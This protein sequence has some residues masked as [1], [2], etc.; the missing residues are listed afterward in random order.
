MQEHSVHVKVSGRYLVEVPEGVGPFPLLAGFHGYGQTAEDELALL[1]R[2]PGSDRRVRCSI[3]ALHPFMNAKGEPGAS[4][5]TRLNRERRIA[6]N[7]AYVDTVIALVMTELP[8]DGRLVLHGF[9]QGAAMA[10]RAAVP[11]RHP[12]SGV[13][14]LGGGVPPELDGL[15]GMRA[16][17]LARGV[18]DRF[19]PR[20][21]FESDAVRLR[22]DGVDP[23]MFL[24][25]GGHRP[26]AEYCDAAGS[27]LFGVMP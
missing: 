21:Q 5:M 12:V 23:V 7:V 3:E 9:S 27:F 22:R 15:G 16:V 17:H 11:G 20:E 2:I 14:L 26:A 24:H 18:R 1:G 13:M 25:P 6:E 10:C 4:W 19:Y 8:V